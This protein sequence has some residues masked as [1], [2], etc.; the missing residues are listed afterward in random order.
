MADNTPPQAPHRWVDDLQRL[1]PIRSQFVLAGN[2][3]DSFLTPLQGTQNYTLAP[4]LRCLWGALAAQ[5]YEFLLVFDP[6]E[7]LRPYPNEPA[8]VAQATKLLDLK[9]QGGVQPCSLESLT[10]TMKAVASQ[11]EA[12]CALVIDFAS[13]IMRQA[14]HLDGTEHRFFLAAQ[15]LSLLANPVMPRNA[16]A[17]AGTSPAKALFNP[18][19]WLVNRAQDL[20]SWLTLDSARIAN[21]VIGLPDYATR[22]H[23]ASLLLDLFPGH[24]VCDASARDK[25]ARGFAD[26][27]DGLT[28]SAMSDIAQL[29]DRQESRP[30]D[31][32]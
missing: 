6:I 12:R 13:R 15:R 30:W 8:V 21:L 4:L 23:A 16:T 3:R 1:L 26:Q 27:T 7:G 14:D 22:L 18:V 29:A 5:G 2:I 10:D 28:L 24:A 25:H 17:T 11:R 20:P 32:G 9:L 31:R 19:L